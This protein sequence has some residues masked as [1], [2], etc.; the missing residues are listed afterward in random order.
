MHHSK[1]VGL[2]HYVPETKTCQIPYTTC[3]MVPEER[4]QTIRCRRCRYVTE[5]RTCQVQYTTCR[6]ERQEHCC[7]VPTTT[8]TMEQYCVPVKVYRC[9]PVCEPICEP[10]CPPACPD[11]PIGRATSSAE[12]Y[13]RV[14]DRARSAIVSVSA[15]TT[16]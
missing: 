1:I 13:A 5:E 2:G 8:C 12:W 4:C 11:G 14:T 10:V 6:M 15:T 3:R 7:Q 16:K 9:V